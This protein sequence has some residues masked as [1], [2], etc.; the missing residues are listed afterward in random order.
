MKWSETEKA[1]W[2]LQNGWT[3]AQIKFIWS[4]SKGEIYTEFNADTVPPWWE[5]GKRYHHHSTMIVGENR[6]EITA[7]YTDPPQGFKTIEDYMIHE[8]MNDTN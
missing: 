7:E 2:I 1:F 5:T 3:P 4:G 8:A 6:D